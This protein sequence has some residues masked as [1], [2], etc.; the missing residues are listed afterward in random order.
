MA[1]IKC[2][3]CG[4]SVSSKAV[5]CPACGN[6]L[7]GGSSGGSIAFE[8]RIKE[9]ENEKY[10]VLKRSENSVELMAYGAKH[11]PKGTTVFIYIGFILILSPAPWNLRNHRNAPNSA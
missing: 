6:P 9:Y 11:L 1:L 2:P 5:S 7:G 10:K 4:R 8:K 3:D